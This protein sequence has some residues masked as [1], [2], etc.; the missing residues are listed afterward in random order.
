MAE[1]GRELESITKPSYSD[2]DVL[3]AEEQLE[4]QKQK[5]I[6]VSTCLQTQS[7]FYLNFS[8]HLRTL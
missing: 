7:Q 8:Q 2:K 4:S 5:R 3:E 1:R 6:Q